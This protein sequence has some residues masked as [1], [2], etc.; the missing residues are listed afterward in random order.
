MSLPIENNPG[1]L[2]LRH[3]DPTTAIAWDAIRKVRIPLWLK[4]M[5]IGVFVAGFIP[6]LLAIRGRFDLAKPEPRIHP[7]QDMDNM[8]RFGAQA[9]SDIFADGRA[10]RPLVAGTVA[11]GQLN[12]DPH[13]YLGYELQDGQAKFFE[14]FPEEL[15]VNESFIR[16]GEKMF[17]ISC[18]LCHGKDGAGNGPIHLRALAGGAAATGWVQP[19][20][21]HSEQVLARPNGHIYNTINNGIRSMAGY[22]TQIEPADRWAIVAYIRALQLSRSMPASQLT[23][24]DKQRL[25]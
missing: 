15:V 3:S 9:A 22:G 17:N 13:F 14:A 20:S 21:L 25:R 10:S 24:E 2:R 5:F 11:R 8:P 1:R 16:R 19:T 7:I 12:T 18:S 23:E 6:L 4:L